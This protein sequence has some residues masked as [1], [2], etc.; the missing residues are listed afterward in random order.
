[1][2]KRRIPTPTWQQQGGLGGGL[3]DNRLRVLAVAG[4]VIL[5]VAAVA[6]IGWAYLSDYIDD[7]NRPG[8]TAVQ[9]GDR[10]Y[11]VEDYTERAK[12]YVEQNASQT[13]ASQVIPTLNNQLIEEAL[14][15]QHAGEKSVTATDDE[16]KEEIATLLG[17]TIDDPNF[18]TR[19][20]ERL[21]TTELS[22]EEY[23]DI[24]RGLAIRANILEVFKEELPDTA[25]SVHFRVIQV[26]DQAKADE[27]KAQLDGGAD[28]AELAKANSLDTTTKEQGGDAGWAPR[29]FLPQTQRDILFGLEPNELF[30]YSPPQ[31]GAVLIY[32]LLEK[33]D[34]EIETDKAEVLASSD[35]NEWLQQKKDDAEIQNDMDGATGDRAKIEYVIDHAELTLGQ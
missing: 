26:E 10:E 12:L 25:E 5:I 33:G 21:N 17:L 28:F 29:D 2:S 6:L 14:L 22:E 31:G 15:L 1:M 4:I 23:R 11:T 19:L 24:A 35:Y 30:V 18:D 9:I 3:T 7:Q 27:L 8:S 34:H 13:S 32:Q 16:V 20:Q